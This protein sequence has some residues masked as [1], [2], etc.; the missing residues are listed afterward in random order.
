M[1]RLE[2]VA[3]AQ[4]YPTPPSVVERVAALVRPAHRSHR[5]VTRLLD[6]CCGAGDALRQ[7]ADA[8]GGGETYGIELEA[9]RAAEARRVLDHLIAGSA[10]VDAGSPLPWS[11]EYLVTIDYDGGA[12][13]NAANVSVILSLSE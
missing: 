7:F 13:G 8:I 3:K 5:R 12:G 9:H 4:F 2:G 6:P 1:A 10:F 11:M